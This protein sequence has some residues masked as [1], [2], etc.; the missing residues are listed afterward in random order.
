MATATASMPMPEDLL[1]PGVE[2]RFE[3]VRGALKEKPE[4]GFEANMLALELLRRL[5]NH[6]LP[7]RLGFVTGMESGYQIFPHEPRRVRYPDGAF[8]RSG[9]LPNNRPP[10]GHS[11][12][13][14]DLVIEVISP[15]DLAEEVDERITDF[16]TAG[17]PLVWIVYPLTRH[18]LVLRT[19][20]SGRRLGAKDTLDGE[21]VL[22]GFTCPLG[23]LFA[24][25]GGDPEPE[26]Q[27]AT[28]PGAADQPPEAEPSGS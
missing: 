25:I 8:I 6:V 1:A 18:I 3:L 20:K 10:R 16:L 14:P 22:P 19:D 26:A 23:E 2:G 11:K 4:M 15:N 24:V 7:A 27:R 13:V 12:I 17:V 9:K 5:G 21:N 28:E